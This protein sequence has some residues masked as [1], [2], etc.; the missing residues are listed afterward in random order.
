L[1]KKR[2]LDKVLSR[3]SY[4]FRLEAIFGDRPN[5][6]PPA[7]FDS[8]LSPQDTAQAAERLIAVMGGG[9]RIEA[10]RGEEESIIKEGNMGQETGESSNREKERGRGT[11]VPEGGEVVGVGRDSGEGEDIGFEEVAASDMGRVN[12][13]LSQQSALSNKIDARRERNQRRERGEK[14]EREVRIIDEE[15][16]EMRIGRGRGNIR[17]GTEQEEGRRYREVGGQAR[18]PEV[19]N[20][21]E[22]SSSAIRP[23][24]KRRLPQRLDEEDEEDPGGSVRKSSKKKKGGTLID[25]VTILASAKTEGEWQKFDFLNQHLVQ[26]SELRREELELERERLAIEREKAQTEQKRTELMILQLP[27]SM[28]SNQ[29]NQNLS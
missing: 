29:P 25:A 14:E 3:C 9:G 23:G 20:N 27:A 7:V 26:Q 13:N 6:R 11:D 10:Q 4:F 22:L 12:P 19:R 18:I 15:E 16:G 24:Q 8:G 28:R 17:E 5:I 1:E 2:N 21:Q